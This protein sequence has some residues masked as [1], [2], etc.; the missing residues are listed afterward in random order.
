M[1]LLPALLLFAFHLI[2]LLKNKKWRKNIWLIASMIFL[3]GLIL[4]FGILPDFFGSDLK[5][6]IP[7]VGILIVCTIAPVLLA[8]TIARIVKFSLKEKS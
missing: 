2:G 7:F 8:E 5:I 3:S 1:L 4:I 6:Q